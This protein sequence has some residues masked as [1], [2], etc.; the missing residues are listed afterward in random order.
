MHEGHQRE[1]DRG[2]GC[3]TNL[4][5]RLNYNILQPTIQEGV[6]HAK[7]DQNINRGA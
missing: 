1:E 2:Y 3:D 6:A 7:E 5:S 4:R